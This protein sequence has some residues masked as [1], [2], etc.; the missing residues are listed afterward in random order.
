MAMSAAYDLVIVGAGN[1]GLWTAYHLA[2]Q[3]FGRIAICERDWAG[4]GATSR[5]AGVVRQQGGSETAIKLGKWARQ[6]YLDLGERLGLD[7]GFTQ[8]GYYVLAQTEAEKRAFLELVELRR[9]CGVE[10]EWLDAAEGR[11]RWPWLDWE[12][13]VGATYTPD[14]GYVQPPIVARN[15]TYAA[16]RSES[17][18]LFE[19]CAVSAITCAGRVFRVETARGQLETERILDAGG[20]RGARTIGAMLGVDVPV[21]AARHQI[22]TFATVA[23]R[24]PKPFPMLFAL[25]EGIY[26]RPDE[27]GALLGMSNPVEKADSSERYQIPFDWAYSEQMRPTWESAFPFLQGQGIARA[28][29]ASIDYTPDHLPIVDQPREGL[30]VLAAGGHGMMWG[31][32]LGLKM[33]ELILRGTVTDLPADEIS[34]G[35]FAGPA[36]VRDAIA[37]PFPTE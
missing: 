33:A 31:P 35:R 32:A 24:L 27:H 15:I 23:D 17:I 29:S 13:F 28:W 2:R 1:L 4:F 14:D 16:L 5:S 21:A 22:V 12:H 7:S 20:P 34:L 9:R 6:L 19:K 10:N 30:Y 3:G 25:G 8:V 26:V 18:D 37:L 36:K 11:R